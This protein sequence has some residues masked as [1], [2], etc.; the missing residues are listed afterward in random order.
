MAETPDST[1]DSS[2]FPGETDI[3]VDDVNIGN[4]TVLSTEDCSES[5]KIADPFI[6]MTI[7]SSEHEPHCVI[8]DKESSEKGSELTDDFR[9]QVEE[10]SANSK[11]NS[12]V[13]LDTS[14]LTQNTD[15]SKDDSLIN[16]N[17]S[18]NSKDASFNVD[19]DCDGKAAC[20]AQSKVLKRR[21]CST[22]VHETES[23]SEDELPDDSK[24]P[25]TE[26]ISDGE[27]HTAI[28]SGAE[29]VS[30]DELPPTK[31]RNFEA[32]KSVVK[33][34]NRPNFKIVAWDDVLARVHA[35]KTLPEL[36]KYWKVVK[37]DPSDFTG[38]T[39]LLQYV[40]QEEDVVAAR[41]A[42]DSFLSM[43]PYCYGYWRK[44]ADY[45][46]RRGDK[47]KCNEVFNRGL[48][49][50]PLSVDLW[51]HYL[52]HCKIT[53]KDDEKLLRDQFDL[54]INK[55][56]LEFRSDR[57]WT[58]YVQWEMENR[59]H[60]KVMAI[61]DR[62]LETPIQNLKNHFE[63]FQDFVNRH[64]PSKILTVD[65]FFAIRSHVVNKLKSRSIPIDTTSNPPG[66]CEDANASCSDEETIYMRERII[67]L[68]YKT[69]KATLNKIADRWIFETSIK[70]PYFHIKPLEKSQLDNWMSYLDF[71]ITN[72]DFQST[73]ILFE[74]AMI[75]CAMYQQF[76]LKYIKY[77]EECSSGPEMI[78]SLYQRAC[79]V[80]LPNNSHIALNWAAFE[81]SQGNVNLARK[82]LA[83]T[84]R[85]S[86]NLM[87]VQLRRIH[88]ERRCGKNDQAVKLFEH[89][90][91]SSS[92]K[93][94]TMALIAK[95]AQFCHRTLNDHARA[96]E[97]LKDAA[98]KYPE[99]PKIYYQML[100]LARSTTIGFDQRC[101]DVFNTVLE[102]RAINL[103]TKLQF[104]QMKLEYCQDFGG[105][106]K[107]LMDSQ[108]EYLKIL[109]EYREVQ[110][111]KYKTEGMFYYSKRF[112][113][114][115]VT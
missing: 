47:N 101:V 34:K 97:I 12:L 103:E 13:S 89:Y 26:A 57:L 74:R 93:C 68:R 28:I 60:Q 1:L 35:S 45:E 76:W 94:A 102:N 82:I 22:M 31:K 5:S 106:L 41:D 56:G 54:A 11:K 3:V 86:N 108:K 51:L 88:F 91:S 96:C 99:E 98:A 8:L 66:D 36:E 18:D 44:Y 87:L 9:L 83:H 115:F 61:Y 4:S 50:I 78:R 29:T 62:L 104:A 30:D 80:H 58:L 63:D 7:D 84:D 55:C 27:L 79:L 73:I 107:E 109:Q 25:D 17:I 65:E 46:K 10:E 33:K 6:P 71:E 15:D 113:E 42:Y 111:E 16:L 95:Y 114:N 85:R 24:V 52:G 70:R 2:L 23:V 48:E 110:A 75:A 77:L 20:T 32:K 53:L 59:R 100:D 40:D 112:V 38:W 21:R 81:E 90:I 37:D 49:A 105:D 19:K 67:S 72:G 64:K 43:Y 39:Y 69:Y 14:S 92:Q